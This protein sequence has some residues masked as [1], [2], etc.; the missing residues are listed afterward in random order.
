M[1]TTYLLLTYRNT[2]VAFAID[3]THSNSYYSADIAN[4][5]A[6]SIAEKRTVL[7]EICNFFACMTLR[8]EKLVT[9]KLSACPRTFGKHQILKQYIQFYR[10]IQ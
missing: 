8:I 9:V 3:N 6:I 4:S 2:E 1:L 7:Q 5:F 10:D